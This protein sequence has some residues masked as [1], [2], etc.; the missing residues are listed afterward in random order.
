VNAPRNV[1]VVLTGA[2]GNIGD[3]LI[4]R[5][6]LQWVRDGARIHAYIGS[7]PG[8]W[9]EQMGFTDSDDIYR[10]SGRWSWMLRAVFGRGP[11][12]LVLD[13]G[14]VSLKPSS[15]VI[16]IQAALLTLAVRMRGGSVIRPPRGLAPGSPLLTR[17][18]RMAARISTI[19]FWRDRRSA[20]SMGLGESVPDTAFQEFVEDTP[21]IDQ[22]S[23]VVVSMRAARPTLTV[24]AIEAL[25]GMAAGHGW[26][27]VCASQVEVDEPRTRDLAERLGATFLE[28]GES[29]DA[30]QEKCLRA[31]Y[32]KAAMVVTDR[33]HVAILG[34]A[35]GAVPAELVPNPT[36]KVERHFEQIGVAGTSFDARSTVEEQ[37]AF[38]EALLK[39]R[40]EILDA[41]R[42]AKADVD[43]VERQIRR[44]LT[45]E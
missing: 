4:R 1:F 10:S 11:R 8:A 31:L 24:E 32:L 28:W 39:R 30:E 13:P 12:A 34:A 15:T 2:Y 25:K 23:V 42:T 35:L 3:A 6:V 18:H 44:N 22:R 45:K 41:L 43:R 21:G 40:A 26:S 19:S 20:E 7:A 29:S 38:L 9:A 14:E 36:G 17:V 33:L 16:E 5:R 37:R 27:I